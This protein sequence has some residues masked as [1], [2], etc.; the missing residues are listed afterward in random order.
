MTP[1][2]APAPAWAVSKDGRSYYLSESVFRAV[3][4]QPGWSS[5]VLTVDVVHG[6]V[7]KSAGERILFAPGGSA[8]GF[9]CGSTS[10]RDPHDV[11]RAGL[12]FRLS[13]RDSVDEAPL[14]LAILAVEDTLQRLRRPPLEFVTGHGLRGVTSAP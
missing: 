6:G 9:H 1:D 12:L 11:R 13:P 7:V 4:A 8:H 10:S 3:L 5:T 14:A 2:L